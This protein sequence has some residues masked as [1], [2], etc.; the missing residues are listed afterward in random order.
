MLF[1]SG[2]ETLSKLQNV[3]VDTVSITVDPDAN[4]NSATAVDM[5]FFFKK[6]LMDS[7]SKMTSYDYYKQYEQ[8]VR[9]NPKLIQIIRWELAP[10]QAFTDDEVKG[11]QGTPLGIC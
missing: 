4:N 3:W 8:L 10:G 7:V 9:D 5:V 1:L 11:I 2:C 6:E